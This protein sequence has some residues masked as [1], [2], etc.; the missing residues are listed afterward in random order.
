MNKNVKVTLGLYSGRYVSGSAP[1]NALSLAS[2][3][4]DANMWGGTQ[5][6]SS[7]RV[8]SNR[9]YLIVDF[10]EKSTSDFLFIIDED[11]IH[12]DK[13]AVVLAN[14]DLPIV[15]GLYFHRGDSGNYAPHFYM[16]HGQSADERRGHGTAVNT[17]YRA[18]SV[19]VCGKFSE[20]GNLP[21]NNSPVILT[22]S[23][24]D[25]LSNSLIPI[26]ASGWGCMML[27]RDAL[28]ALDP[29]YLRDE[30]GL[31]GDLAF[32]KQVKAKGIPVYG[33]TSVICAHNDD[34][35]VGLASF[36]NYVIGLQ[37]AADGQD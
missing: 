34:S 10:L 16:E 8:D 21:Y 11:M 1:M 28:E 37:K 20:F 22:D 7:C 27:R 31:N 12:P 13:A 15:S 23:K 3:L 33:D 36:H 9:N 6:R 4:A 18:M 32:F 5:W 29:P 35:R 24:G 2:Q 14:R 19:E 30:P 17:F 26:D 25:M